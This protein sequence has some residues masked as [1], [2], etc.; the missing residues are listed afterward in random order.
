M[1][2]KKRGDSLIDYAVVLSV[3]MLAIVGMQVY[4]RRSVQAK[5]KDMTDAALA[6]GAVDAGSYQVANINRIIPKL[7]ES[8]GK[9]S[10]TIMSSTNKIQSGDNAGS[11]I[12]E[13]QAQSVSNYSAAQEDPNK[14]P[15]IPEVEVPE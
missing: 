7:D 9:T 1:I 13:S 3:V 14:E 5:I 15:E 6:P 11:I 2:F 4:L 12:Y 10:Q 8:T